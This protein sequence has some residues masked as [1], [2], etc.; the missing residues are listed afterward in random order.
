[1]DHKAMAT[2]EQVHLDRWASMQPSIEILQPLGAE[3]RLMKV[4]TI[5]QPFASLIAEKLKTVECRSWQTAYRGPLLITSSK[6]PHKL[7]PIPADG[8]PLGVSIC[9]VELEDIVLFKFSEHYK[10]ACLPIENKS[11]LIHEN[12][13]AWKIKTLKKVDPIPV[14]GQVGLWTPSADLLRSLRI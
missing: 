4:L 11:A 9:L 3:S 6:V 1:M 10:A 14:K 12:S 7:R 5:K 13:W 2:L 8:L